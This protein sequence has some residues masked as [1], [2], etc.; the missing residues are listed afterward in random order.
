MSGT[1]KGGPVIKVDVDVVEV[2]KA[3]RP[4]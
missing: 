4:K 2:D 1:K 3:G